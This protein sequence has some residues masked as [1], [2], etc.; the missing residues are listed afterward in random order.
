MS[1]ALQRTLTLL[2][3]LAGATLTLVGCGSGGE[4]EEESGVATVVPPDAPAFAVAVIRPEGERADAITGLTDA[5]VGIDD[6][7]ERIV[8][9][10]DRELGSSASVEEDIEPW[11][12]EHVAIFVRSLRTSTGMGEGAVIVETTDAG[13][14]RR[15]IDKTLPS[16]AKA[17]PQRGT[18]KGVHYVSL[19]QDAAGLVDG[20]LVFGTASSFKAA[21]DAS[22]GESLAEAEDFSKLGGELD[23]DH[24]AEMWLDLGTA[25]DAAAAS[26]ETDGPAIDAARAAFGPLLE[27]PVM[28]ELSATE[29]TVTV[30]T[31]AAGG[32]LA[33]GETDLLAALPSD[34]WLGVA[35]SNL[36]EA[37][38]QT[39][40]GL[41]A[42]G[43]QLGQPALDAKAI[44]TDIR[45]ETGLDL[46]DDILSWVGGSAGYVAGGA[47]APFASGA[48]IE[49]TDAASSTEAIEAS[50][51]VF[52]RLTH[53]SASP[54]Q[55]AEAE[56]GFQFTSMLGP[57][58]E[59]AQRDD[60]LVA[61]LGAHTASE[62]LEPEESLG[63]A[64][65]FA[66]A[67]AALGE[68]YEAMA[69]LELQQALA[70]AGH[71]DPDSQPDYEA[72]RP[73]TD[74]LSYLIFG[75]ASED[76]RKLGRIVIGVED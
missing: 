59:F 66:D 37:V 57:G 23:D 29:E 74:A 35:C 43:A 14:A 47:K 16:L 26:A 70:V 63:D 11:L 41:G 25:L 22:Q 6:P 1:A 60:D 7:A 65:P 44:A 62:A 19:D 42:L 39:L 58:L 36:G 40:A 61:T 8:S 3:A 4:A 64:Q 76:D 27:D 46:E 31:S 20:H 38:R 68:E 5:V 45:A 54:T 50:Q 24:L 15:F 21:V 34:A 28:V 17:E 55:L 12:G 69:Y 67:R 51:R 52:E 10:V 13:A 73:Y 75:T 18:Y 49:T 32:P 72:A 30:D 9:M 71:A 33:D 2:C 53:Q 56:A 48:V